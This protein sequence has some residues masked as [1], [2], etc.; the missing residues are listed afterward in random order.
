V[1]K[2][3]AVFLWTSLFSYFVCFLFYLAG[4]IFKKEWATRWGWRFFLLSFFLQTLTIGVRWY[5]SGRV[6]VMV[7]YEH[8][9]LGT[10]FIGLAT[11]ISGILYGP[12]KIL[13]SVSAPS[14]LILLGIGVGTPS[15]MTPLSPPY[16]SNWLFIHI[17]FAWFA[18]GCFFV[19]TGLA[20]VYLLKKPMGKEG[21]FLSKFPSRDV[22]DEL[23]VRLIIFGFI[24]QGLMIIA[25][26][27]WAH[28]LWGRYWGWDPIETWSLIC[29]LVY[30][31]VLHL[32]LMM[33]W[34]GTKMAIIVILALTTAIVYFW[35]I[36][37]GPQS[38]TKLMLFK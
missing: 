13:A 32:R 25:G 34:K 1:S 3:E 36:G 5:I 38:H 35:G 30:G 10:W 15:E 19:A 8:Y 16:K 29:W 7:S 21:W 20:I 26:A 12:S 4:A 14:I 28:Q 2:T 24:C 33:G 23:M 11:I 18:W 37:F 22:I 27:I 17:G 9:Q 6:P 31:V